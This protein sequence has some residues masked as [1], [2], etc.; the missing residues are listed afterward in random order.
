M[1]IKDYY[2]SSIIKRCKRGTKLQRSLLLNMYFVTHPLEREN[3]QLI[4]RYFNWDEEKVRDYIKQ[5][6]FVDPKIIMDQRS[7]VQIYEPTE[8]DFPY[9]IEERKNK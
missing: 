5:Y 9:I 1:K 6:G 3:Y 4:L 8:E 7:I 2:P